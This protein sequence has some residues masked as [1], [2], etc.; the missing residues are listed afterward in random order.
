MSLRNGE[1]G[2]GV[3]TK[4]LHWL[5]VLAIVGQLLGGWTM[6]ADD[7]SFDRE[8]DR[9]DALEDAGND[10]ARAQGDAA[11]DAF[12]DDID[13]MEDQLDAREDDY[14][15][16]AFSDVFSGGF[17]NDGVSLPEIH[18]LLGLSIMTLGL[19]RV[20]WRIATPLP[21]WAPYLRQGERRLEAA[22]ENLMLTLLFVV[23]ATGLLLVASGEDDWLPA[24]IVAQLVLLALIA[25]HVGLV[26]SH[27]V[28]RRD[29]QLRRML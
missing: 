16:A 18:V 11:E 9:I 17:L 27:T 20:A 4:A 22:L 13:R 3:V 24:H 19:V 23:P 14:V 29:G 2:Y 21:P 28:V 12:K 5:T 26:L 8:K 1:H 7:E 6:E 10:R 15:S 25:V